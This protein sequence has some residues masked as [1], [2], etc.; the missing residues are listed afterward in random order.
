MVK[1]IGKNCIEYTTD[2]RYAYFAERRPRTR[3][4]NN[5]VMLSIVADAIEQNSE[6]QWDTA[7]ASFKFNFVL[8][9]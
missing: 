7:L 4:M 1:I 2:A 9:R 6:F 5:R 8:S 3:L